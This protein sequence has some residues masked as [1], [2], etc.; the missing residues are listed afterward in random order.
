MT[1]VDT[2][3]ALYLY[4]ALGGAIEMS[5]GSAANTMCGVASFGGT[6]AYIGKVSDDELGEVF[7]HDLRAVGV[8]FRPGAPDATVPDRPVHHRRHARRRADDEHLPRC[9]VAARAPAT[10][11]RT[12]W[13]PARCC[14]W[15]ATSTTDR[16]PRRRSATRPHVAHA[17]GRQVSL[18]LSDSFCVDRHRDDFRSLVADEVDM[19]FGNDDELMALYEVDDARRGG[20]RP[21][22][23]TARWP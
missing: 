4:Q 18:T 14:T 7:G 11:T 21:S 20:R 13:P 17:N 1:L 22:A 3:R 16:R 15:R 12:R 23:A 9:V 10:S 6:A 2:D 5:G 19:L 8:Q